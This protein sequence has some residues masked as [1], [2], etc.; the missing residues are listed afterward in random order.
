MCLTVP[1]KVIE[2]EGNSALVSF[3][4]AKE[5]ALNLANAR[6]GEF[7]LV[8]NKAVIERLSRE[9]EMETAKALS[10]SYRKKKRKERN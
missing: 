5:G 7:L 8:R 3:G 2:L 10:E 6:K 9:E 4:E 1:G